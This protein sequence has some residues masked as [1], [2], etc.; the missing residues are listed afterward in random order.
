MSIFH[1]KNKKKNFDYLILK[2]QIN[3]ISDKQKR[4]KIHN[5]CD[6]NLEKSIS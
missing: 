1:F 4:L 6:R 3:I 5:S 2:T